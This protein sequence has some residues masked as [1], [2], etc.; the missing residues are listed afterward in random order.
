MTRDWN[1]DGRVV[2][3]WKTCDWRPYP[4]LGGG[5]TG[6]MWHPVR[7]VPG[8]GDG[9]YLLKVA[10]GGGARLHAHAGRE[11]FVVLEGELIDS[12][13]TVLAEGDVVSYEPG[14]R[15]RTS[16]PEG[17]TLMV[18][19][20]KPIATVGDG[21]EIEAIRAGRRIVNWKT[22]GYECYPGLPETADPIDWYNVR[23]DPETGE[24]LSLIRF[25]PGASSRL[26][27]HTGWE[28]FV[29]LEGTSTDPDGTTYGTGDVVSLPPGSIHA[30]RSDTGCIGAVVIE[31][32][33][34]RLGE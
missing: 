21:E 5:A 15:H 6:L 16:C 31:K 24:G 33:L 25:A 20:E 12:D 1:L 2:V 22:A 10:P 29:M 34:K 13:G 26:H 3:N 19:I 7:A 28:E 30:S 11:S 18:W 17:C 8:R 23:A 9:T 14:T 32:P 27:E 4:A